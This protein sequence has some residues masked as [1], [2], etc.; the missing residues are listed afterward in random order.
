MI[1]R[2]KKNIFYILIIFSF[3][4][5]IS[6][7]KIIKLP[8]N[9][10]LNVPNN[11][12]YS[13]LN[14]N[15]FEGIEGWD[16]FFGSG[17]DMY[18]LGTEN[19]VKLSKEII[20]NSQELLAPIIKKM[21]QMDFESDDAIISYIGEEIKKLAEK[22]KYESVVFIIK[23]GI[24]VSKLI[25]ADYEFK[26]FMDEIENMSPIELEEEMIDGKI[27]FIN[28]LNEGLG[29]L[30]EFYKFDEIKLSKDN[31]NQPYLMLNY[32]ASMPPLE[33]IGQWFLFIH[34][35]FPYFMGIDCLGCSKFKNLSLTKMVQPMLILNAK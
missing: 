30:K 18:Y 15:L 28:D 5:T 2:F 8:N 32:K 6:Y 7:S 4:S 24:S 14:Q 10:K 29:E 25:N 11:F 26:S 27:D 33:T 16:E 23:G 3:F 19:S 17:S 20:E 1:K 13:K 9:I 31:N 34:D 21:E 22:R 12:V 35:D